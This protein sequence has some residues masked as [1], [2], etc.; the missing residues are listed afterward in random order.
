MEPPDVETS[1]KYFII[2]AGPTGSGKTGLVERTL[3]ELG[4]VPK[5]DYKKFIFDDLIEESTKYKE[6]VNAILEK[7]KTDCT[8]ESESK[9]DTSCDVKCCEKTRYNHP[10]EKMYAEFWDAYNKTT[11]DGCTINVGPSEPTDKNRGCYKQQ[12]DN[13]KQF[14]EEANKRNEQVSNEDKPDIVVF[15]TTGKEIPKWMLNNT[16]IPKDYKIVISYSIVHKTQLQQRVIQR[17]LTSLKNYSQDKQENPAPRL[18]KIEDALIQKIC[19]TISDL[20]SRCIKPLKET[21]ESKLP[22]DCGNREIHR[23]L[24]FNN[25]NSNDPY[26]KMFDSNDNTEPKLDEIRTA[27]GINSSGGKKRTYTSRRQ[28]PRKKILAKYKTSK[29]KAT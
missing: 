24:V 6:S 4:I 21:P 5:S 20:Y 9:D 14:V 17:F 13:L 26:K 28:K 22:D 15:E 2:T 16:Y 10:D 3:K 11:Y 8:T 23:L 29:R 1:K 18:P 27:F 12:D 19:D 7:V 25:N